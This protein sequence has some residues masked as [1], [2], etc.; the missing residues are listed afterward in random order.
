VNG[1][2]AAAAL[3]GAA[4]VGILLSEPGSEWGVTRFLI[5]PLWVR[6]LV[7]LVPLALVA[8]AVGL[9]AAP[10]GALAAFAAFV[11][12]T[13]LWVGLQLKPSL[14]PGSSDVWGYDQWG[15]FILTMLPS[16]IGSAVIGAIASRA[17]SR[18]FVARRAV[19]N[20]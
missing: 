10:R 20:R 18:L 14:P 13:A 2:A 9:A 17:R 1:R 16:A 11:L 8:F 15:S 4:L 3:A 6:S 7:H 19:A 12:G 5:A